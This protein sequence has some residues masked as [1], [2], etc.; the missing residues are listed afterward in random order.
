MYLD[1]VKTHPKNREREAAPP[2]CLT[3]QILNLT[4]F[5]NCSHEILE[6]SFPSRRFLFFEKDEVLF[7]ERGSADGVY[8]LYSGKVKVSKRGKDQKEYI[9]RLASPGYI[10]G[11]S[12]FTSKFYANSAAALEKTAACFIHKDDFIPFI[13]SNPDVLIQVMKHICY[14]IEVVEQNISGIAQKSCRERLAETLLMLKGTYGTDSNDF[15]K[16]VLSINDLANFV[17]IGETIMERLISNLV[18]EKVIRVED[19]KIQL[20]NIPKLYEIAGAPGK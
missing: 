6:R 4:P 18:R 2:E 17:R 20:L 5:H 14:E 15:L 12:I 13:K 16:V 9:T 3:C 11:L 8:C 1:R 19:E 10:L 7:R